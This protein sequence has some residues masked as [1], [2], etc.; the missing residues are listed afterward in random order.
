M[1]GCAG[2]ILHLHEQFDLT[3]QE[4]KDIIISA[5]AGKLENVTAKLDGQN[6][7]FTYNMG[8]NELRVARNKTEM[9]T[10]GLN[11]QTLANKFAGRD[12][13]E[14]A[15]TTAFNVLRSALSVVQNSAKEMLFGLNGNQY[16]SIEVIYDES[17]NVINYDGN[18]IVFHASPVF[19]TINGNII[20]KT[21]SCTQ[22]VKLLSSLINDMQQAVTLKNWKLHAPHVVEIIALSDG[23]HAQAAIERINNAMT[24]AGCENNDTLRDFLR[25]LVFDR[26]VQDLPFSPIVSKHIA[27]RIVQDEDA[28]SVTDIKKMLQKTQH[29][30]A[31]DYVK[32]VGPTLVRKFIEP[33]ELAIKDFSVALL[34]GLKTTLVSN[35]DEESRAIKQR[36]QQAIDEIRTSGNV[37]AIKVLEAE[38]KRFNINDVLPLEGVVFRWKNATWKCTGA[39]G[40]VNKLM[41][42]FRY[43][44]VKTT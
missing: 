41:G 18:H 44:N 24:Y 10:G 3:F 30:R 1:S 33:I 4:I 16:Y 28:L 25:T 15:F 32:N 27:K 22:E 40:S 23:T 36:L 14:R 2:H 6:L 26:V 37:E 12:N 9:L 8:L 34:R 38:L 13:V 11:L 31:S 39:F 5:S 7:M 17:R 43:G 20:D 35:P 42:L 19:E 21:D 29:V